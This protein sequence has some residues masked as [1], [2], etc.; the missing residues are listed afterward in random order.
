LDIPLTRALEVVLP[1]GSWHPEVPGT[2]RRSLLSHR[3][4]S[5]SSTNRRRS[6]LSPSQR[7]MLSTIREIAM[8]S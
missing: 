6:W 7:R 2:S 3:S 4:L 1:S 5:L 8:T